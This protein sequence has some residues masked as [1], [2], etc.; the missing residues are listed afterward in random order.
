M[1][2]TEQEIRRLTGKK[3]PKVQCR[4]LERMGIK[5]IPDAYGRPVVAEEEYR[6][7]AVGGKRKSTDFPWMRKAG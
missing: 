6:R 2:L 7:H 5:Y 1:F 4:Q 3:Y